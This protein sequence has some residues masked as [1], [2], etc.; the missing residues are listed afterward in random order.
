M[1][2]EI[3][4]PKVE[5]KVEQK[6]KEKI[7]HREIAELREPIQT[8]LEKLRDKIDN[9]EYNL[10]IGD[11]ASGRI[12]TLIFEKIIRNIYRERGFKSPDTI[13][14]AGSGQ[15][16]IGQE[17][18]TQKLKELF[19]KYKKGKRIL[20]PERKEDLTKIKALVITDVI[21]TGKS[22]QPLGTALKENKIDLDIATVGRWFLSDWQIAY[23]ERLGGKIYSGGELGA[24]SIYQ[25]SELSGVVKNPKDV[26]AEPLKEMSK[27]RPKKAK[28]YLYIDYNLKEMSKD[29][30]KKAAEI[31]Q[32]IQEARKDV[33]ILADELIEWY[34]KK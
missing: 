15:A 31:Q 11:D 24:P 18:K 23:E 26:F 4:Q 30:P 17:D 19:S 6:K 22:L 8:L 9:G 7:K 13:F 12:P 32:T 10:I 29:R 28:E 33:K 20:K 3:F 1:E 25:K 5:K 2:K 16:G 14:I 21:Q 27:D 34:K